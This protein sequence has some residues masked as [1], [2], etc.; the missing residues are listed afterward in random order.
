MSTRKNCIEWARAGKE[1]IMQRF[2]A[3][4][5]IVASVALYTACAAKPIPF[6]QM[7]TPS[8]DFCSDMPIFSGTTQPDREFHRIGPVKSLPNLKSPAE[9]L[10]SL[11]KAACDAG[12]DGIVEGAEAEETQIDATHSLVAS[13]TGVI[14]TRRPDTEARPLGLGAVTEKKPD[15]ET[16]APPPEPTAKDPTPLNTSG[17]VKSPPPPPTPA[18]TADPAPTSTATAAPTTTTKT[19]TKTKTKTK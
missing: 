1:K 6:H 16:K 18:I 8:G 11:R 15:S 14:W 17:E 3:L 4:T 12:A 7:R 9:R 19:T 5:A 2:T 13:G 10:E